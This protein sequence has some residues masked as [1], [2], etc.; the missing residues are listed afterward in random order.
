[1]YNNNELETI[2]A[3]KDALKENRVEIESIFYAMFENNELGE[4]D[5]MGFLYC[6]MN[7]INPFMDDTGRFEVD[8]ITYYK[9]DFINS[10]VAKFIIQYNAILNNCR[11]IAKCKDILANLDIGDTD[12]IMYDDLYL[13]FHKYDDNNF[14]LWITHD[15]ND[16][17]SGGSVRGDKRDIFAEFMEI[18]G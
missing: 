2:K 4:Y 17:S 18:I 7:I 8:P 14:T 10:Q 15:P 3:I 9:K 11:Y 6:G 12:E 5:E 1:M 13:I 16:D